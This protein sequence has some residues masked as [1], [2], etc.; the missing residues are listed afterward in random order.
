[1]NKKEIIPAILEKRFKE[2]TDKVKKAKDSGVNIVQIDI[3]DGRLTPSKTFAS[4]GCLSSFEKLKELQDD[5]FFELDMIVDME[6]GPKGRGDK[7][8]KSIKYLNP[9]RVIFHYS[10]VENWDK[11]FEN[12]KKEKIK[13]ALGIWISDD[14]KRI[15]KILEKYDFDYIQVMGIEKVGY[16]GQKL[17]EKVFKKVKYFSKK[18]PK[19][20]IQVDGG[21][22]ID[23]SKRL[24]ENGVCGFVAGSGIYNSEGV[25]ENIEN[26][27]KEIG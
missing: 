21:V 11:I 27:K 19:M 12:L 23:N 26:F 17:S 4:G 15:N 7:F 5:I 8:L 6:N 25:K 3:C 2:I 14:V 1:M 22:K 24:S 20:F 18:Y 9:K 10:G 16:G 13:I